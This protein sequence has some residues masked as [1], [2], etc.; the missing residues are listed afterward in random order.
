MTRNEEFGI[1]K[2]K[3]NGNFEMEGFGVAEVILG[4][5]ITRNHNMC[6]LFLSHYSYMNKMVE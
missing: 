2:V 1:L 4:M 3:L 5:V 6:E